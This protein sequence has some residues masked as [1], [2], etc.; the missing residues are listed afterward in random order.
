[1]QMIED[2]IALNEVA[3]G[4]ELLGSMN[5]NAKILE[6]A[7]SISIDL[8]SDGIRLAGEAENV[9]SAGQVLTRL[10]TLKRGGTTIESHLVRYLTDAVVEGNSDQLK[11]FSPNLI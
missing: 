5:G 8:T 10:L 4:L 1:M 3:E 7:F 6:Q 11:A 2:R 9:A